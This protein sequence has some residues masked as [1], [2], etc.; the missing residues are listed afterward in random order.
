MSFEWPS[1]LLLEF[2]LLIL[3]FLYILAQRRRQ[4]YALRFASLSL[5]KDALGKG[6][7][8]L[9]H[10]PPAFFLLGV[11]VMIF[12]MARP[13]A[14]VILPVEQGTVIL[15][16]D[17]SGSMRAE[18]MKPNR[19]EA[20]KEAARV[21]VSKQQPSVRVGV[22]AFSDNA[23]IVQ[24]PTI[25]REQILQAINRLS[26]QRG[27]AIGSGLLT[28]LEA[29]GEQPVVLAAR[30]QGQQSFIMP[31]PTPTPTPLP[32]GTYAPAVV[33]LLSDGV[34]NRGPNPVEVIPQ[35]VNR[36][37]RVFTVGL[38]NPDGTILN[39]QGR[40]IRVRLDEAVLK[41]IAEDTDAEYFRADTETDLQ[42][43]YENLSTQLV[44]KPEKTELTAL[45]TGGALVL[46]LIAGFL[47]LLWF[48]RLP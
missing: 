20:A 42:K 44:L 18:D 27:T 13:S 48:N 43:V 16:I 36:G 39:I 25:D 30:P 9:R 33:I 23:A 24:S 17:V 22:V 1:I 21:F 28:S 7:G 35:A 4:K 11:G 6:P 47:S 29:I 10:I 5:V 31:T 34:S 37:V 2:L 45:F 12:A 14:T 38:G 26:S 40:S 41:K 3:I 8:I 32:R 46:L 19:L 15:T